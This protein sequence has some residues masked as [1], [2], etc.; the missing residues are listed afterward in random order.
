MSCIVFVRNLKSESDNS[1]RRHCGVSCYLFCVFVLDLALSEHMLQTSSVFLWLIVSYGPQYICIFNMGLA[2]STS[3]L[4]AG[5]QYIRTVGW[6]PV[7]PYCGLGPSTSVLWAG[8]QYIRTVGWLLVHPYCGL[9]PST[10]VLWAAI[11][12]SH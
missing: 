4:W 10:S 9:A 7:H 8:S 6:L 2:S 12:Y 5:S 1:S 3:V 11:S